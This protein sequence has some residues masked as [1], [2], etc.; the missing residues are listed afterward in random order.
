[1]REQ[2]TSLNPGKS[3]PARAAA[4]WE[5]LSRAG[6]FLLDVIYPEAALCCGCGRVSDA[7]CLCSGCREELLYDSASF[8]WEHQDF[9]G[10]RA[11]SLRP[12]EGL[13]RRLVIRLK[14]QA[15]ACLADEL[16]ALMLPLPVFLS[17]P[18][19]TVVTWVPMPPPRLR[20]RCLDHGRLLAE[21]AARR[22]NLTAR[23]LLTRASPRD[24]PTQASLHREERQKNLRKAFTALGPVSSPVLLID[25]V[26]TTGATVSNCAAALREAGAAEITALTITRAISLTHG[27]SGR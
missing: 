14:H 3:G 27:G 1:M 20:E 7:G 16:T 15:E 17:F 22:L 23:P 8:A 25:D 13:A 4:A 5:A 21:S 6:T 26:L 11:Y 18:P 2:K 12:H 24:V 19:D 10:F 9:R